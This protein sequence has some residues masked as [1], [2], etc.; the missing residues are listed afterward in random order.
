M[1]GDL[2]RYAAKAWALV[3][4]SKVADAAALFE[5]AG[6]LE[7]AVACA[8]LCP[9]VHRAYLQQHC[10]HP[11]VQTVLENRLFSTEQATYISR[12]LRLASLGLCAE[13]NVC[14]LAKYADSLRLDTVDE[15]LAPFGLQ[16]SA[17]EVIAEMVIK[18]KLQCL[19]DEVD[20]LVLFR[21]RSARERE[22]EQ[23]ENV[24]RDV[25]RVAKKVGYRSH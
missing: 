17:Q 15:I 20:N 25:D 22:A 4:N 8:C 7:E 10:E 23:F 5:S 3:E 13:Y 21:Q 14:V 12:T 11:L 16:K 2:E 19:I 24:L 6:L 9:S 18:G 1:D